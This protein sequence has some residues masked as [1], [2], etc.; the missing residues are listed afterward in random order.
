MHASF[1]LDPP[2]LTQEKKR[3]SM[4][5]AATPQQAKSIEELTETLTGSTKKRKH[6]KEVKFTDEEITSDE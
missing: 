1:R 5:V 2:R 3:K 6:A 4:D